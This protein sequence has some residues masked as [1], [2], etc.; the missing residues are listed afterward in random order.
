VLGEQR[1]R[2]ERPAVRVILAGLGLSLGVIGCRNSPAAVLGG[3]DKGSDMD[4]GEPL[5]PDEESDSA[6]HSGVDS[7]NEALDTGD[8][9][10]EPA[11]CLDWESGTLEN[12]GYTG[13]QVE[14]DD[15]GIVLV[16]PEGQEYSALIGEDQL[17]YIDEHALVLRSSH[18]GEVKSVAVMQTPF[19]IVSHDQLWWWQLSEVHQEGVSL[20]AQ[21]VTVYDEELAAMSVP[22]ETGGY[23]PALQEDHSPI[24][25]FP[26]I[27][28]GEPTMGNL[29]QQGV[30]L[31]AFMG[32][33]L[34]LRFSQH[35]LV[36]DNGFFTLLDEICVG[37]MEDPGLDWD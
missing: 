36:Q 37:R 31:S 35:T 17:D 3:L 7:G 9:P 6:E 21:L 25:G 33:E 29:V 28:Q 24:K 16:A 5:D 32:T 4:S 15:G 19:F 13:S 23:I 14:L 26:E 12:A 2:G 34:A 20:E 22:V 30:D 11:W 1:L 18:Q 27:D 8:L 10:D